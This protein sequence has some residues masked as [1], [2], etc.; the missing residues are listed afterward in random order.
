MAPGGVARDCGFGASDWGGSLYGARGGRVDDVNPALPI[1]RKKK[2]I[3]P[4]VPCRI[5]TI[6]SRVSGKARLRGSWEKDAS[7]TPR[8]SFKDLRRAPLLKCAPLCEGQ[9]TAGA[10]GE[11]SLQ[12]SV[13]LRFDFGLG[14]RIQGLLQN[15]SI[16]DSTAGLERVGMTHKTASAETLRSC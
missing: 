12:P 16:K 13:P 11:G 14:F 7:F 15:F 1:R 5:D 6:N 4:V 9:G 3:I 8:S 2:A 10:A